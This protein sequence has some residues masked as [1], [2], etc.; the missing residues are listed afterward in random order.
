MTG[1][2]TGTGTGT[3]PMNEPYNTGTG[4]FG[5]NTHHQEGVTGT[6][7]LGQGQ[8]RHA[9]GNNVRI[10]NDNCGCPFD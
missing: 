8:G 6:G 4:G 7:I 1:T 2:G 5:G 9:P 10:I 3:A